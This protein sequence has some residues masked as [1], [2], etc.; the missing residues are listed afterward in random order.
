[1]NDEIERG[2]A[3]ENPEL[4]GEDSRPEPPADD[5]ELGF[6]FLDS[7]EEEEVSPFGFSGPPDSG[8]PRGPGGGGLP[9]D[10]GRPGGSDQDKRKDKF[11]FWGILLS[12]LVLIVASIVAIV[13]GAIKKDALWFALWLIPTSIIIIAAL[14]FWRFVVPVLVRALAD[15]FW[16]WAR[17]KEKHAIVVMKENKLDCVYVVCSDEERREQFEALEKEKPGKLKVVPEGGEI[18]YIGVPW[19]YRVL[20]W[21]GL[22][23]DADNRPEDP[24]RE[25][26]LAERTID[27]VPIGKESARRSD[28]AGAIGDESRTVIRGVIPPID[29]KD[30]IQVEVIMIVSWEVVDP[31]KAL[32]AVKYYEEA[33]EK[34]LIS[35]LRE[36]M[37]QFEYVPK[38]EEGSEGEFEISPEL[39]LKSRRTFVLDYVGTSRL[40]RQG[41]F[42]YKRDKKKC[43]LIPRD[44]F[45]SNPDDYFKEGT[46]A[47]RI[48]RNW[49]IRLKQIRIEDI[50]PMKELRAAVNAKTIAKANAAA[51]VKEAEGEATKIR[52]LAEAEKDKLTKEGEGK[53]AA[54]EAFL[55]AEA[56]GF[57]AQKK[58]LGVSGET[59]VARDTTNA[60]A[61]GGVIVTGGGIPGV[62]ASVIETAN[63]LKAASA[64]SGDNPETLP[65][66]SSSTSSSEE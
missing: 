63:A 6:P 41:E 52:K 12:L 61:K 39:Q 45:S 7:E 5:E 35:L 23:E 43:G 47:D 32:F 58:E 56:E 25:L 17:P 20:R 62:T 3:F 46:P 59:I 28:L 44:P 8:G 48:F 4:S 34:E 55:K 36:M 1:M 49:G 31:E 11:A 42:G 54:R 14:V 65:P 24:Q 60:L 10:P 19:V 38:G 22:S 50:D 64:G 15:K 27:F 66:D 51:K 29:T 16:F 13:Y 53:A 21:W 33:I 37:G 26:Y 18:F 57:A 30:P 40:A 2:K 9:P